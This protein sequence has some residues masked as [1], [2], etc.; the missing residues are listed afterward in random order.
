MEKITEGVKIKA[1]LLGFFQEDLIN[2]IDMPVFFLDRVKELAVFHHE[3]GDY[4]LGRFDQNDHWELGSLSFNEGLEIGV[5]LKENES[6]FYCYFDNT[7]LKTHCRVFWFK[8]ESED[9]IISRI[10]ELR[11]TPELT[12]KEKSEISSHVKNSSINYR[13][14]G[15]DG[16]KFEGKED[17]V[18]KLVEELV[19]RRIEES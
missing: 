3:T 9:E 11:N 14:S 18:R 5:S 4:S 6:V 10:I 1:L 17:L 12:W 19:S 15:S 8:G 13:R 7:E 2:R 16:K